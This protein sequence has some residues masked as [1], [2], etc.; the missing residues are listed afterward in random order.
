MLPNRQRNSAAGRTRQESVVEAMRLREEGLLLREIAEQ[1]GAAISTVNGWLMDPNGE[2]QKARK[3]N[4]RGRC[5]DCGTPTDGSNGA[6]KAPRWCVSCHG[7]HN[8]KTPGR[9]EKV[10]EMVRLRRDLGLTNKEI[11]ER[12][13]IPKTTIQTELCRMRVLGF[14]VPA[15]PYNN[16]TAGSP[17][18]MGKDTQ[19]LALALDER[20]ITPETI[21]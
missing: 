12:M 15:A 7:R 18:Y 20:G 8:P 5:E 3:D 13:G 11:A 1:M 14:D 2:R 21:A 4:Y 17:S 10:L 16:A 6:A 9:V 19:S